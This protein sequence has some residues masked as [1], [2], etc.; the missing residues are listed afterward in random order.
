VARGDL[1]AIIYAAI[2]DDV[3]TIFGDSVTA[4]NQ[5]ADAVTVSFA[6]NNTRDFDLIIG[7]DGLHSNVRRVAF[8]AEWNAEYYLGCMVAAA[9][10]EGYRPRD[11]LRYMTYSRPGRSVARFSLRGDRT[12]F[13]FVF[14]SAQGYA[15]DTL[16]SRKELLRSVF[17]G[18]HWE[19]ERILAD[20]DRVE[21]F[22]FDSVSQV[23]MPCWS[24]DRVAL[25]GDAAACVSLLAGEG[26]GL[27]M[28][29]AYVLAG[30]LLRAA[31][32]H[33]RAFRAY[34]ARLRPFVEGKQA[35]AQRLLSVFA[36]KT[37]LGIRFRDLVLQA[38]NFRP[39][40]DAIVARGLR[41][42]F[43]LPDYPM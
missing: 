21:D 27:A 24:R 5:H 23:R 19:C 14:R 42:D 15:P 11:E 32:D 4:I 25:I 40:S 33:G 36:T 3:E 1:A 20:L 30:E 9:V 16:G 37:E 22:Y 29:E 12:L 34:E 18:D 38:M 31:D 6:Q 41:D 10:V 2:E 17:G 7:A 43:E 8:G 13:L 28:A 35:G 39:L 26:T